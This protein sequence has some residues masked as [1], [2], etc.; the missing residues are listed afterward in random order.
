MRK[1]SI[2]ACF[3]LILLLHLITVNSLGILGIDYGTELV[4]LGIV[5]PGQSFEIL[6]DPASKRKSPNY[7]AFKPFPG[8]D[9]TGENLNGYN[10]NKEKLSRFERLF[11]SDA[12]SQLSKNPALT[13]P[14]FQDELPLG[15]SS[16]QVKAMF[17]N[18]YSKYSEIKDV[19]IVI[20]SSL[21]QIERKEWLAAAEIAGINLLSLVNQNTAAAINLM[22][23]NDF[24]HLEDNQ[25]ERILFFNMGAN[26]TEASLVE[27]SRTKIKG[28]P[29]V[30][31]EV[32]SHRTLPGQGGSLFDKVIADDLFAEFK[33]K[34]PEVNFSSITQLKRDRIYARF[35]TLGNKVK[36]ILSANEVM[37]TGLESVID[38]IDFR[39]EYSR[40]RLYESL[41]QAGVELELVLTNFLIE[42]KHEQVDKV[43]IL[44]GAVRMPKIKELLQRELGEL[45]QHLNGDESMAL[46]ATFL[47]A[48]LSRTFRVKPVQIDDYYENEIK[49]SFDLAEKSSS[50]DVEKWN[51]STVLFNSSSFLNMKKTINFN[52]S[53]ELVNQSDIYIHL[54][55]NYGNGNVEEFTRFKIGLKKVNELYNEHVANKTDPSLKYNFGFTLNQNGTVEVTKA[56]AILKYTAL[57]NV[58]KTEVVET[59]VPVSQ[60][61]ELV[62]AKQEGEEETSENTSSVHDPEEVTRV[63]Q[64]KKVL[65]EVNKTKTVKLPLFLEVQNLRHDVNSHEMSNGKALIS[66]LS[67][68]EGTRK[69]VSRLENELE[70]NILNT[71]YFI[72]EMPDNFETPEMD[73]HLDRLEYL[74][75]WLYDDFDA[76]DSEY[77]V[78]L[79]EYKREVDFVKLLMVQKLDDFLTR[80]E[81][82]QK[83]REIVEGI[84]SNWVGKETRFNHE[85]LLRL[86][87]EVAEFEEWL[88]EERE[89]TGADLREGFENIQFLLESLKREEYYRAQREREEKEAAQKAKEQ[90]TEVDDTTEDPDTEGGDA[91]AQTDYSEDQPESE[92]KEEL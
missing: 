36:H 34:F 77:M 84:K 61:G 4:K 39:T 79:R 41:E 38:D 9:L 53:V 44:G 40:K 70:S 3:G 23:W 21:N 37:P 22:T 47:G 72:R 58:S 80:D 65:V 32:L 6:L 46:G 78:L 2:N 90:E 67:E 27:F 85:I 12:K 43:E 5:L 55:E 8:E 51:K 52:H 62:D 29:A 33:E 14:N 56:S 83:S 91:E 45:G 1:K 59:E 74:E 24:P 16:V 19:S 31:G 60:E 17:L 63:N 87:S 48:N 64:T 86:T 20:P 49:V 7:I 30:R 35:L 66:L 68:I 25:T 57:V 15:L 71:R 92:T 89:I 50:K 10:R 18:H 69:E 26:H 73:E 28:K 75:D 13:F 88:N 82:L 76:G 54:S 81:L 11:G 42:Y